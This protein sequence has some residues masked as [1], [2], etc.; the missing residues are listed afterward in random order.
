MKTLVGGCYGNVGARIGRA[1]AQETGIE[2]IVAGRDLDRATVFAQSPA[3]VL[4]LWPFA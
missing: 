4:A 1:L 2:L 3:S